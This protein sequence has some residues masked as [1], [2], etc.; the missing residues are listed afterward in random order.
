MMKRRDLLNKLKQTAKELGVDYT[1]TEGGRHTRVDVGENTTQVPRHKEIGDRW[2][3]NKSSNRQKG[4]T[5]NETTC[6]R[7]QRRTILVPKIR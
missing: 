2:W 1:V 5:H 7:R 3:P 6:D 4:R